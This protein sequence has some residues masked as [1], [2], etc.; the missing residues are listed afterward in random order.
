[1]S[2][3]WRMFRNKD[4]LL[5]SAIGVTG[6]V[7]FG[8]ASP[9]VALIV[10]SVGGRAFE[11]GLISFISAGIAFFAMAIGGRA[12][13]AIG[14]KPVIYLALV[15]GALS[16]F[17]LYAA[18]GYWAIL[19]AVAL[20]S[21]FWMVCQVA[22]HAA[23]GDL[24][25]RKLALANAVFSFS[26]TAGVSIGALLAGILSFGGLHLP[27]LVVGA[28]LLLLPFLAREVKVE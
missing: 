27:F 28:I 10:K 24:F 5:I 3:Q 17:L 13:D 20:F 6:S 22:L 25:K 18:S 14:R 4:L 16:S 15:A 2:E 1:M 11:V 21:I 23:I 12:S 8:I 26:L 9:L 19:T 7:F